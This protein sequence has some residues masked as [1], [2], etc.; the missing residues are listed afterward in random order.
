MKR[1]NEYLIGNKFA[2]GSGGNKTSFQKGN[3]P[4]NKNKKG[5]HLS[6]STEFKKG[7]KSNKK[8]PVGSITIRKR[9]NRNEPARAWIKISEPNIWELRAVFVWK[10]HYG[11]VP[12]GSTVHHKD[13]NPLNDSINNLQVMT[14]AEHLAEH[15][16]EHKK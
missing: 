3:T 10:K 14:R 9:K 15:R 8:L 4:W 13:R 11:E 7:C 2:V 6:P 16:K 1:N 5:I 12:K